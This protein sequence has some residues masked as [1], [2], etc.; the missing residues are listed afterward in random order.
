[1]SELHEPFYV[2]LEQRVLWDLTFFVEFVLFESAEVSNAKNPNS[3]S[4]LKGK[5]KKAHDVL[6]T[7]LLSHRG[8]WALNRC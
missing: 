6:F 2:A 8:H 4:K 5:A 1:M 3:T 7:C